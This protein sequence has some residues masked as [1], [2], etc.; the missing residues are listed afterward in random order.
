VSVTRAVIL[1]A[2]Y[3][4]RMLPATKVVPKELMPLVDTPVIEYIFEE[5]V[6]SGI[7]HIII[8]TSAGKRAVEDHFGRVHDLERLL[9]AK[10]DSERL[11]QVRRTSQMADVVFV[12]Q[13]EMGGIADAVRTARRAVGDEPFVLILP[14]DVIVAEPP[15]TRQL[16]DVFDRVQSSV[17]C[18]ERVPRA[19]IS[20]YGVIRAQ[21]AGSGAYR[22]D[23][24]VEKPSPE[25]APSDLAIVGR[26]VF[27]PSIFDA[28]ADMHRPEGG[29]MQ[30][31][32]AMARL[33]EREP[34][35]ATEV[36]GKRYDTGQ[37][38][39]F[40]QAGIELMLARP[41][42][43]AR[44]RDYLS[45]LVGSDDYRAAAAAGEKGQA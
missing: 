6:Q 16:L 12:R 21:E 11:E 9:E 45:A 37:P 2:G 41:A 20:L 22:V 35:Y 31:T 3:G 4:T 24:L 42:Y 27:T 18:V 32:D 10:G 7:E 28:I 44:L 8:V 26:Y 43:A 13:H 33:I 30:I 34:L 1:A 19:R 36:R 14:D 40:L 23:G 5:A 29:E 39:G 38:F 17:V 25:E 15:A